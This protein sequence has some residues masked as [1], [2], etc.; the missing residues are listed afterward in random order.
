MIAFVYGLQIL[1][2][3][4]GGLQIRR[5]RRKTRFCC[6]QPTVFMKS[7]A[8]NQQFL[9][10]S[11]ACNQ[12]KCRFARSLHLCRRHRI[13]RWCQA[14][15]LDAGVFVLIVKITA[16][17]FANTPELRLLLSCTYDLFFFNPPILIRQFPAITRFITIILS[18]NPTHTSF[19]MAKRLFV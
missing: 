11:V 12:H 10:K 13:A 16:S 5:N 19:L 8:Y 18:L 7:V 3:T 14:A 6:L 1:I 2:F 15:P 9:A 17:E 4:A